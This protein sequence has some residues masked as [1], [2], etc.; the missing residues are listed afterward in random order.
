MLSPRHPSAIPE[1]ARSPPVITTARWVYFTHSELATGARSTAK[2]EQ[3]KHV[4]NIKQNDMPE[5]SN[6][7]FEEVIA[8]LWMSNPVAVVHVWERDGLILLYS[9]A[10]EGRS[11]SALIEKRQ[12]EFKKKTPISIQAVTC[13][14]R[15]FPVLRICAFHE[16]RMATRWSPSNTNNLSSRS[17]SWRIHLLCFTKTTD[18]L[19]FQDVK[20]FN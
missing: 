3:E 16:T 8:L 18:S 15:V 10:Q 13:S 2:Q 7:A 1:N 11:R 6:K 19:E 20:K 14:V 17:P 5:H 12:H 4:R 9:A